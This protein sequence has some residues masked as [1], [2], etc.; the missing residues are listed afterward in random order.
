MPEVIVFLFEL[1][2]ATIQKAPRLGALLLILASLVYRYYAAELQ[3]RRFA[4]LHS[5]F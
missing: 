1:R 3:A 2:I 5:K 4:W